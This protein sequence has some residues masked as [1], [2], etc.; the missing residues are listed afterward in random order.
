MDF[1]SG[2]IT[3]KDFA[4]L[5]PINLFHKENDSTPVP[6]SPIKNYHAYFRK[7]ITF[8]KGRRITMDISADDYYKLYINGIFVS[9][10]PAPAYID[11]YNYNHLDITPFLQDGENLFAVHVYYHGEITRAFDSGD[12][13][14]GLLAAF[15]ADDRYFCGTNQS[16]VYFVGKDSEGALTSPHKT[17]FL[18]NID[19]RKKKAHWKDHDFDE[20]DCLPALIYRNS[21][22]ILAKKPVDCVCVSTLRPEKIVHMGRGQW[23]LDFGTELTGSFSM[24]AKGN[25][26]QKIR[27]LYGEEVREDNPLLAKYEM[28]CNC[29]Y[30]ETCILSGEE[31][32]FEFFDYKAFRYMNLFTDCDNLNPDTFHAV[33]QHHAFRE[34]CSIASNVKWVEEIW[35]LCANSLKWGVQEGF[36]DCPS[37]EKGQYLGDFTVSGLAYLYLT[38]DAEAYRKTLFDFARTAKICKGL[39]SVAPG[40]LMQEIADFSLQYPM[41]VL[42]YYE[43]T[44]DLETLKELYPVVNG[45]LEYF[46]GYEREDGLLEHA[47]DKW[48]LIDWPANVRDGYDL[49]CEER[50]SMIP[51]HNVLNAHYIGALT[52]LQKIRQILGIDNND[53][54]RRLKAAFLNAFYDKEKKIFYDRQGSTHSALHSNVLPVFYGIAPE[55]SH[56]AIKAMIL[57]KG[58]I[59]GTQ[60]SYFVLKALGKMHAFAEELALLTNEGV[61]GWVNMLREG[62]T[63][64]FEAWGKEQKWN[65]SLLHPWSCAP[66]IVL[67]E[68]IL[69][70]D[71]S[72]FEGKNGEKTIL[73]LMR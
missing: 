36:L 3:T 26:G 42:H 21:G 20:T 49:P 54:V 38:G 70:A 52:Y 51:C 8:P 31:D 72:S 25:A 47:D 64:C 41:Q 67:I 1:L 10:G 69:K 24:K 37:R 40:G 12:N 65:T 23:F 22:H 15:Y 58:L 5:A 62:G 27:L 45:V 39:M 43:Y 71:P 7:K 63:T 60:F 17:Q 32:E 33:V 6:E 9:Q 2:W 34:V 35:R 44:K 68:D 18:E 66:I 59:C 16:W 46:S 48:N 19:F 14:M 11:S 4:G 61:H 29:T 55:E 30:D 56:D 13:R 50:G 28:R 57:E 53:K 73:T